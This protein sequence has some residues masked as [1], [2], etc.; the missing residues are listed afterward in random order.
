[1][2]YKRILLKISGEALL[3]DQ[4]F[5][6]DQAPVKMIA[7][8]IKKVT[9]EGAEVAVVVGGGNIFRGMKNSANSVWTKHQAIMSE[10]LQPL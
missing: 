8:E 2:K 1:M 7:N 9:S 5:G 10:C 6:I 4:Q 3:G